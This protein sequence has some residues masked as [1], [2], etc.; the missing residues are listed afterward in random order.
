MKAKV[1]NMFR[2][3]FAAKSINEGWAR[4]VV[5]AFAAQLDP[6]ISELADIRT[7]VSEAVTNAVVHGYKNNGGIIYITVSYTHDRVLQIAVRDKGCG[8]EN[9][10]EAMRPLYTTDT[11]GER[12]GMGFTIMKS[13]MD[14]LRVTSRV[15]KGTTVT[16]IKRLS[17][18]AG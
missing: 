14:K 1:Q 2:A 3:Q 4:Q 15:G 6:D 17:A 11:T 18:G 8:I 16:M 5:S 12:G 9:V 13:F 7:A 10:K